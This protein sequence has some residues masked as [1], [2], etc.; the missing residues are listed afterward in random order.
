M[1][2][3]TTVTFAGKELQAP[4]Y[5]PWSYSHLK[6]FR[7][8][9]LRM[10]HYDVAKDC[11]EPPS[12]ELQE[13]FDTHDLLSERIVN[14]KPLPVKLAEFEPIVEEFLYGE[15]QPGVTI[16]GEHMWGITPE[17]GPCKGRLGGK[18]P[19]PYGFFTQGVWHRGK[20]DAVKIMGDVALYWDW[21]TG[22]IKDDP[23]QLALG[24]AV[25]MAHFP[26]VQAVRCEFVWL[27]H[28]QRSRID[29]RRDQLPQFWASLMPEVNALQ[30][31]YRT[32]TF[33]PRKNGLCQN[34]CLVETC[35]HHP[36]NGSGGGR[37]TVSL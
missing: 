34:Y 22:K 35:Q 8:C 32:M 30:E 3:T 27:Y 11:K 1:F 6:N 14:K 18:R 26:Q 23:T 20:L 13:G 29:V 19:D 31:A 16:L 33:T 10:F 25:I 21:K 4:T 12:A 9:Q 37:P 15:G 28:D 7:S 5:R 36:E 17:F 24:A 2:E